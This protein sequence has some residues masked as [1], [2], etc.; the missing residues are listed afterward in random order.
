MSILKKIAAKD[1]LHICDDDHLDRKDI[2]EEE[3]VKAIKEMKLKYGS[4]KTI[5][6]A[7]HFS[8]GV[9]DALNEIKD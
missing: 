7:S 8:K 6:N 5:V 9:I 3:F 4:S 2:S 1:P